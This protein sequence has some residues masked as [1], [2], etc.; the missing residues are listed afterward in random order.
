MGVG[1]GSTAS[2]FIDALLQQMKG[3]IEGQFLAQRL[4]RQNKKLWHPR[5]LTVMKLIRSISTQTGADEIKPSNAD[6]QGGGAALTREK[7]L[8]R[9][10][11]LVCIVDEQKCAD[12]CG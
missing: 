3:Q 5:F 7:S 11:N 12:V 2:H 9:W 6:D 1:T 8:Q 4:Q 10:Q